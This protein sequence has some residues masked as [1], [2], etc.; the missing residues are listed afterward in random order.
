MLDAGR[1]ERGVAAAAEIE[2]L[3]KLKEALDKK[4]PM[5]E[6]ELERQKELTVSM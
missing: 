3:M 4:D 6:K 5:Q 2:R 1:V